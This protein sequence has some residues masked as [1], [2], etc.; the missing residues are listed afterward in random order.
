MT[1]LYFLFGMLMT[2]RSAATLIPI[3]VGLVLGPLFHLVLPDFDL[4][5]TGLIGGTFSMVISRY[6]W[7]GG[8]P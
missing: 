1:P 7:P 5:L 6:F 2:V 8:K 3:L 4:L